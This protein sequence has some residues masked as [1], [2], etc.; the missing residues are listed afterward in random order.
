[1]ENKRLFPSLLAI[2]IIFFILF[3][4]TIQRTIPRQKWDGVINGTYFRQ[5]WDIA[6][7]A[8]LLLL[9]VFLDKVKKT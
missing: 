1:M 7:L 4:L 2:A 3:L 5:F 9:Y 8:D 6:L